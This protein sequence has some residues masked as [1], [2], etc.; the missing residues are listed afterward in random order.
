MK[1]P[2]AA[3]TQLSAVKKTKPVD[4]AIAIF[5]AQK[6]RRTFPRTV[7]SG[8]AY[9]HQYFVHIYNSLPIVD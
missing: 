9:E 4:E 1:M 6:E 7:A 3:R 2:N 5:R 8:D